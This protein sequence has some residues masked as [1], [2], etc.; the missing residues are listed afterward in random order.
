[1]MMRFDSALAVFALSG[2]VALLLK[3][4]LYAPPADAQSYYYD[5]QRALNGCRIIGQVRKDYYGV[6][7]LQAKLDCGATNIG[8][9]SSNE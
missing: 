2:M 5:I 4:L 3:V 6:N 8:E 1:M 9:G 7:R